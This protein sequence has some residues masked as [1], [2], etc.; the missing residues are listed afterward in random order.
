MLHLSANEKRAILWTPLTRPFTI[1]LIPVDVAHHYD[2]K[3]SYPGGIHFPNAIYTMPK[4]LDFGYTSILA[5][6]GLARKL[7]SD[8]LV[9]IV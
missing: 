2:C 7:F 5:D 4:S 9:W 3:V 8:V 6:I 1:R